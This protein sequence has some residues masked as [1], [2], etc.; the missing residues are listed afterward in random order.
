M[1]ATYTVTE[2]ASNG[3][4]V[5][6]EPVNREELEILVNNAYGKC[7]NMTVVN[8]VTGEVRKFEDDGE[9]WV[10]VA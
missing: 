6:K 1:I 4:I 10:R 3:R 5:H 8:D 7:S 2:T 9:K